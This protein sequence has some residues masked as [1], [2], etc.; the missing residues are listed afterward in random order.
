[1]ARRSKVTMLCRDGPN[2]D[3]PTSTRHPFLISLLLSHSLEPRLPSYLSPSVP[4]ESV[5]PCCP[6]HPPKHRDP[7]TQPTSPSPLDFPAVTPGHYTDPYT[8]PHPPALPSSDLQPYFSHNP[9]CA[10]SMRD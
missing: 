8:V 1:M 3:A 9:I 5:R 4:L 7:R 10:Q 6:Q 2:H